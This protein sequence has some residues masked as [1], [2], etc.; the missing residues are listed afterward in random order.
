M[1]AVKYSKI[2]AADFA[3]LDAFTVLVMRWQTRVK[4]FGPEYERILRIKA[5]LNAL[6]EASGAALPFPP[7]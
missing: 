6:A 4:P 5:D 2:P 7:S 3:Q 1:A